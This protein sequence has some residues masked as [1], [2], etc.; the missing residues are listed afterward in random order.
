MSLDSRIRDE[1]EERGEF[2]K[3]VQVCLGPELH[4]E[5]VGVAREA[6]LSMSKLV[7]AM[8]RH[9]LDEIAARKT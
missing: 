4:A 8:V 2:V 9:C 5:F 3:P 7:R 1:Q 6:R